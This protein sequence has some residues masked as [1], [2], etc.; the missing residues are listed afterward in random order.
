MEN[1]LWAFFELLDLLFLDFLLP[2]LRVSMGRN[3][4]LLLLFYE[5]TGLALALSYIHWIIVCLSGL[6]V[7]ISI[8]CCLFCLTT[9]FPV[10]QGKR[11]H[12]LFHRAADPLPFG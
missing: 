7:W 9:Y 12:L 10:D 11:I 6:H 1:I 4:G 3:I 2:L 8:D 5:I